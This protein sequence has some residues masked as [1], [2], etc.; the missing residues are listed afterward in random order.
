MT[1]SASLM[2]N[3]VRCLSAEIVEEDE[4]MSRE[5]PFPINVCISLY[6]CDHA[7]FFIALYIKRNWQKINE[8]ITLM[9]SVIVIVHQ[10]FTT[11]STASSIKYIYITD[12]F[13][14]SSRLNAVCLIFYRHLSVLR[15]SLHMCVNIGGTS[16]YSYR[17]FDQLVHWLV[18]S[19]VSVV[20]VEDNDLIVPIVPVKDLVMEWRGQIGTYSWMWRA[21][22]STD[23]WSS[24]Y[25]WPW[26]T[27]G[28]LTTARCSTC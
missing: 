23:Y 24:L 7:V 14:S 4:K 26:V 15:R 5:P 19:V 27:I 16:K 21:K 10:L 22:H 12:L 13:V 1:S 9:H 3:M 6:L 28:L 17:F 11:V 8:S 20:F 25:E 2:V 18:V